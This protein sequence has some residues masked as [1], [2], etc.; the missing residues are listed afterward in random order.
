MAQTPATLVGNCEFASG[1]R[2]MSKLRPIENGPELRHRFASNGNWQRSGVLSS[3]KCLREHRNNRDA[4]LH[5]DHAT[6]F[7]LEQARS[8]GCR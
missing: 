8:S 7:G 2:T 4:R 3:K 5:G 1:N 6:F